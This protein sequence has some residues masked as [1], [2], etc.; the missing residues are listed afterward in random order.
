MEGAVATAS[1]LAEQLLGEGRYQEAIE[2]YR[3][4]IAERPEDAALVEGAGE[5]Y[6]K[7]GESGAARAS[8][9]RALELDPDNAEANFMLASTLVYEGAT[10]DA[11]A[12]YRR[13][14]ALRPDFL[15]A[16]AR[17]GYLLDDLGRRDEAQAEYAWVERAY[18]TAATTAPPDDPDVWDDVG[19]VLSACERPDDATRAYAR[20]AALY[21]KRLEI[22][23]R[24]PDLFDG[25]G[26]VLDELGQSQ[27]AADA[28]QHAID[29]RPNDGVAVFNRGVVLE[30]L[31]AFQEAV[32]AYRRA[33]ELSPQDSDAYAAL[34][35]AL[36]KAGRCQEAEDV[37]RKAIAKRDDNADAWAGLA[38][39]LAGQEQYPQAEQAFNRSLTLEPDP[40]TARRFVQ[41][42]VLRERPEDADA[43]ATQQLDADVSWQT[44]SVRA[45]ID[46][47]F[48]DKYRDDSYYADCVDQVN[49]ALTKVLANPA[50][51][52]ME[53]ARLYYQRASA[54]SL[55]ADYGKAKADFQKCIKYAG[56]NSSVALS[57]IRYVRRINSGSRRSFDVPAPLPYLVTVLALAGMG[58][59]VLLVERGKLSA[60]EFFPLALGLVLVI[61]AA[62][63]LPSITTLKL[64]PAELDKQVVVVNLP[65]PEKLK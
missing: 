44:Y 57:A 62:F 16:H 18:Q 45:A 32:D 42:L 64:G 22:V 12:S 13:A 2:A 20:A 8:F 10:A 28:Y 55:M 23:P 29:L 35:A 9:Q 65:P 31:G 43:V 19:R 56:R 33:V 37:C 53:L 47:A 5:A 60:A 21:K 14:I 7:L 17:L 41:M 48:G 36:G 15:K 51:Y 1:N 30:H 6:E 63:S 34:G 26:F 27:E 25:L 50:K 54:Y 40:D 38:I 11:E 49:K 4:A 61:F 39:A 58:Y 24:D 52:Q 46:A 59:G 3:Q